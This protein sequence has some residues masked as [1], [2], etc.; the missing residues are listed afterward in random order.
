MRFSFAHLLS[1]AGILLAFDLYAA[2]SGGSGLP[3]STPSKIPPVVYPKTPQ[4]TTP[5]QPYKPLPRPVIPT[6]EKPFGMPGVVGL[7]DGKW[8]GTDYLGHLSKYMTVTF[9]LLKGDGSSPVHVDA[10]AIQK[11]IEELLK[12]ENLVPHAQ[13]TEGPPLPFLHVLVIVYPVEKDRYVIF[14]TCRLFEEIQVTREKFK[15]AGFW[16]GIT[17]ENQD[18]SLASADQV[19]AQVKATVANLVGAFLKRYRL[20]NPESIEG[21]PQSINTPQLTH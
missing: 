8:M 6:M 10:N 5:A 21:T 2:T 9:E 7:Q 15:P 17:W 18:I 19:D 1:L 3:G 4:Q 16:Q 12:A 11:Q 20:Y 13:V 14:T